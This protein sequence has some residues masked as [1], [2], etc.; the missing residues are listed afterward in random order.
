MI[1]EPVAVYFLLWL[2]AV[3]WRPFVRSSA[4]KVLRSNVARCLSNSR[5]EV[6]DVCSKVVVSLEKGGGG[7]VEVVSA[8]QRR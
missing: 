7:T 1:V 4:E 3:E 6:F 5:W 8:S 2:Y